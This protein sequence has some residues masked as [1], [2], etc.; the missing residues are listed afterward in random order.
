MAAERQVDNFVWPTIPRFDGHYD[1]WAMFMENFLKSKEFFDMVETGY[2]KPN[3]GEVLSAVQQQ[4]LATSKLKD[5]KVK[6]YLF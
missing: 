5:M 6:N 1:H 4:Q 2:V 3:E